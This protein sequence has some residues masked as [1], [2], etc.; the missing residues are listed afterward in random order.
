[1]K[2]LTNAPET[3]LNSEVSRM[4]EAVNLGKDLTSGVTAMIRRDFIQRAISGVE[5]PM[6]YDELWNYYRSHY[7]LHSPKKVTSA[8]D[9]KA[10]TAYQTFS[11]GLRRVAEQFAPITFRGVEILPTIDPAALLE[12]AEFNGEYDYRMILVNLLQTSEKRS[13]TAE[14][15]VQRSLDSEQSE[16]QRQAIADNERLI[17]AQ[18]EARIAKMTADKNK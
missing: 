4:A 16:I 3:I 17:A 13:K 7:K 12:N 8:E 14:I 5:L 15:I 6:A 18:V 2:T 11:R 10:K 1:M 9:R